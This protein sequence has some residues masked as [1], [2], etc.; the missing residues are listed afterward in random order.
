MTSKVALH[1]GEAGD[2]DMIRPA[3]CEGFP[4]RAHRSMSG[5]R[6]CPD[7]F[8]ESGLYIVV[9]LRRTTCVY[10]GFCCHHSTQEGCNAVSCSLD[11]FSFLFTTTASPA[12]S[13]RIWA[14]SDVVEQQQKEEEEEEKPQRA[15]GGGNATG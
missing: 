10:L 9:W 11:L 13:G 12:S 5:E 8:D 4:G 6:G 14:H 3:F 1:A 2:Q 15:Q 7:E